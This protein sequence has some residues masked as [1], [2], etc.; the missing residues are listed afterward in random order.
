[1]SYKSSNF[2]PSQIKFTLF[3]LSEGLEGRR[4]KVGGKDGGLFSIVK[5]D[6]VPALLI[7]F[8]VNKNKTFAD[9]KIS[10]PWQCSERNKEGKVP[11]KNKNTS[12]NKN[13]DKA[14]S[15]RK[16]WEFV[17]FQLFPTVLRSHLYKILIKQRKR[18][19]R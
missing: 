9:I 5:R 11:R 15:P 3:R 13:K 1:M 18:R 2:R 6:R 14:P 4:F 19:I 12:K 7:A 10:G 17:D 8:I 16:S